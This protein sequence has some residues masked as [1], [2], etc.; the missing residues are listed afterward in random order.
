MFERNNMYK[1]VSSKI[2]K[3]A[4]NPDKTVNPLPDPDDKTRES[5]HSFLPK[6]R[7]KKVLLMITNFFL[8][9]YYIWMDRNVH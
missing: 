9:F 1:Y 3:V 7:K 2:N 6:K 8:Q 5:N 4:G